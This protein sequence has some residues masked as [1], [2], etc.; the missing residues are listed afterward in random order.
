MKTEVQFH[1]T[2]FNCT[3]PKD[4]FVN[5]CCFG[6]DVAKWLI[7]Q[8]RTRGIQTADEPGQEDFGWYFTFKGG[9]TLHCFVIGYPPNDPATGDRWLGSIERQTGF[10]SALFGGRHRGILPE[11]VEAI[12]TALK[13]S[14]NIQRIVWHE[15]GTDG[16]GDASKGVSGAFAWHRSGVQPFRSLIFDCSRS[17]RASTG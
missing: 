16:N 12:D 14:P 13:S 17:A 6:D 4:Y 1:S 10:L 11:A 2:A 8:L 7:E 15:P 5:D 3:E 9:G